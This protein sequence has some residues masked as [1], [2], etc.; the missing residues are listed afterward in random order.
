[1]RKLSSDASS[2]AGSLSA[3]AIPGVKRSTGLADSW[4]P[5]TCDTGALATSPAEG[6]VA[7]EGFAHDES[8]DL[9]G[10]FVGGHRL[11]VQGMPQR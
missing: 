7:C 4:R 2:S 3:C 8:L 10:T 6:V 1:M 9:V 11:Q 5:A